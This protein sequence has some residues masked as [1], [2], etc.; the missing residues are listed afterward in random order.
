MPFV[1]ITVPRSLKEEIPHLISQS[2]HQALMEAFNV[3]ENDYFHIIESIAQENIK[4]PKEYLGILHTDNI[5]YIQIIAAIG[6]TKEQK[7][8]LYQKTTKLITSKTTINPSDIIIV[9]TEN[10]KENWY[11]GNEILQYFNHI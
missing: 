10:A 7:K 8:K 6:R 2:I 9:L 11:F 5:V 1:R 3:P 4:Y